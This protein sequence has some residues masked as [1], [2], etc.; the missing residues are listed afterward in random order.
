LGP[1][2]ELCLLRCGAGTINPHEYLR[3]LL[4]RI[5]ET[6]SSQ[7]RRP[8]PRKLGG[9]EALPEK[10]SGDAVTVVEFAYDIYTN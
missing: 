10:G 9:S 7:G 8:Q 3:D 6:S 5:T 4:I 2:S 1:V